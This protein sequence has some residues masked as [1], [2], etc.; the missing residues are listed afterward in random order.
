VS[1][2]DE[3]LAIGVC[4]KEAVNRERN[5]KSSETRLVAERIHQRVASAGVVRN[6]RSITAVT[7]R[8]RSFAPDQNEPRQ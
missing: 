3:G 5:S 4:A 7:Y 8:H 6:V 1:G 2:P